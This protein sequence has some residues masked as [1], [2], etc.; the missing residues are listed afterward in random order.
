M[1]LQTHA[2]EYRCTNRK[3][4]TMKITDLII[5]PASLGKK[6]W[7]VDM[8]KFASTLWKCLSI[9]VKGS[10]KLGQRPLVSIW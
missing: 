7:L 6:L 5:S 8:L 2:V 1:T 3:D 4:M 10:L 9:G